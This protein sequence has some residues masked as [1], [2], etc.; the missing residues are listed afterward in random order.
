MLRDAEA[1]GDAGAA[2]YGRDFPDLERNF[3]REGMDE[4]ADWS[5]YVRWRLDAIRRGLCDDDG[6]TPYLQLA[7]KHIALAY[8]ATRQADRS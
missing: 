3:E 6:R 2:I 8:E 4:G 1:R 5:L 7:L